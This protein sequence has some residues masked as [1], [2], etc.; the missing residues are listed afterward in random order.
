MTQSDDYFR[1][2]VPSTALYDAIA[3]AE[4]GGED[5]PW[6]RTKYKDA[7]GGSTAYGP[8]QLTKSLAQGYLNFKSHLFNYTEKEYLKQ[9]V[10]QGELFAKYGNEP[11]RKGYHK[12]Y[13]YGGSGDLTGPTDML[14]YKNAVCKMLNEIYQRH[15][16]DL[17]KTWKEWRFGPRGGKDNRYRKEFYEKLADDGYY[18]QFNS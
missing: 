4:T 17:E 6:I 9:F 18:E 5:D 16:G 8:C 11:D 2:E 13:D 1:K 10:E 12:R 14:L 7:P 3:N 15:D